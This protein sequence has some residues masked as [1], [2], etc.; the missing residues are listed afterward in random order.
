MVEFALV[1]PIFLIVLLAFVEFGIAFSTLNSLNAM[2]RDLALYASE[3][4]NQGGSD[5]TVLL[6]LEDEFS[7]TS[8]PD[9]IANVQIYWSDKNG[10]VVN[11]AMNQYDRTGTMNCTDIHG[12]V[13][14]LPYTAAS[15]TYPE[16]SRCPV[17][18]GCPSPPAAFDHQ[19]LDTIGVRL[20][21][22]YD[23][24]TPL[25]DLLGFVGPPTFHATQEMRI[26]PV[27]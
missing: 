25:G 23:W 2:S 14:T 1:L 7:R 11:A 21:Y 20:T 13:Q 3:A 12:A 26:E 8:N 5:C 24:R 17:I 27:L 4:G 22:I 16:A 6:I 18:K 15:A 19:G 10:N 9:G